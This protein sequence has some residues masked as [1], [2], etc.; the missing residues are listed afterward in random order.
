MSIYQRTI[1][2]RKNENVALNALMDPLNKSSIDIE[3]LSLTLNVINV[4][5][6]HHLFNVKN[7]LIGH[8]SEMTQPKKI[9]RCILIIYFQASLQFFGSKLKIPIATEIHELF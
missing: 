1:N 9:Y 3:P 8:K 7:Y 6:L 4:S 2:H 5:F